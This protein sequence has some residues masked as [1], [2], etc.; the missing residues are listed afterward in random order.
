[1]SERLLKCYGKKCVKLG[2]KFP[3]E[4]LTKPNKGNTAYCPDC[5]KALLDE[6]RQRDM[7][8][9][10]ISQLYQIPWPVKD[11]QIL[12]QIKRFENE[13]ITLKNMRFSL[14]YWVNIMK[15]PIRKEAGIAII[16]S[17]HDQMLAYHKDRLEKKQNT[18]FVDIGV[19][20]V[21]KPPAKRK[22]DY[23]KTKQID[24]GEILNG[25]N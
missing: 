15:Q 17:V 21:K 10:T 19:I 14:D 4:E 5:Y 24:L 12:G 1:M 25:R 18:Q 23:K 13:G 16:R 11:M 9:S 7:L 6:K 22:L 20:N 3:K 8:L 2:I